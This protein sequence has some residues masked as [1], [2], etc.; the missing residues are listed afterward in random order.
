MLET[1]QE[2]IALYAPILLAVATAIGTA[3]KVLEAF[4]KKDTLIEEHSKEIRL[5]KIELRE[6]K[7]LVIEGVNTVVDES[8]KA[9]NKV[10]KKVRNDDKKTKN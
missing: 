3:L 2:L 5:L 4:K 7:N 9:I 10:E 6:M 8:L 1:I